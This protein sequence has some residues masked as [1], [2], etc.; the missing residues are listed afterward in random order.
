MRGIMPL[1]GVRRIVLRSFSLGRVLQA[2]WGLWTACA[3]VIF[4]VCAGGQALIVL[5]RHDAL[6]AMQRDTELVGSVLAAQT[7]RYLQLVDTGLRRI[8]SVASTLPAGHMGGLE[9]KFGPDGIHRYL[10]DFLTNLPQANGFFVV[11][12][13]GTVIGSSRE[14]WAGPSN[15]ADRDYFQVF[16]DPNSPDLYVS[17]PEMGRITRL[18]VIFVARRMRA[19]D[20]SFA[21]VA[22]AALDAKYFRDFYES[23]SIGTS[24]EVALLRSDGK[25]LV[26][27]PELVPAEDEFVTSHPLADFPLTVSIS[28]REV[29][30]LNHWQSLTR[31]VLIQTAAA[32]LG[33]VLVF[34]VIGRQIRTLAKQN[35]ELAVASAALRNSERRFR[36]Y[37]EM[38]SDWFWEQDADLRL[39]WESASSPAHRSGTSVV[40][41]TRWEIAQA[42]PESPVWADHVAQ[43]KSHRPFKDFRYERPQTLGTIRHVSVSGTPVFGADG[44]FQGYR[45]TGRDVTAEVDSERELREARDQAEAANRI[46]S[47]LLANV[48]HELRTPL[49]AIIG[50]SELIT[51]QPFGKIPPRYADYAQDILFSGRH[52]L[53][54]IEGLLDMSKIE[55][56]RF[57]LSEEAVDLLSLVQSC[58]A[59][60]GPHAAEGQVH[61]SVTEES[62]HAILRADAR[63]VRQIVINLLS[64][65]VKFTPHGGTVSVSLVCEG[66]GIAVTVRDTGIG[67]PEDALERLGKPF[68]Q[69]DSSIRRSF[70]GTGLGLAITRELLVLHGGSLRIESELSKGT[71]VWACFPAARIMSRD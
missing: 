66:D 71:T 9:W 57:V 46:K 17:E 53:D 23:L 33:I 63:A 19:A 48:T 18:P 70:G 27:Y 45:G 61:L 36:D 60:L 13:Q 68:Q 26:R 29:E 16:L 30:A 47:E 11:D 2:R 43:I 25:T 40:G 1:Y 54:L 4:L 58:M 20:G 34:S 56:G 49:N 59:M 3:L 62:R 14:R 50:F 35:D 8:Q 24:R 44:T 6:S 69:V 64:N 37:A 21:G 28:L 32:V 12:A 51:S 5:L 41:M 10:R 39:S 67:I 52:L 65:A 15:E 22:V 31:Q 42:D 7:S 38:A 55:A